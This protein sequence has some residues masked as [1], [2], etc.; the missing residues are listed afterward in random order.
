MLDHA[1]S[2]KGAH[3]LCKTVCTGLGWESA[4][5]RLPGAPYTVFQLLNHMIYWQDWVLTWLAGGKPAVPR[6]AS[7]SWPGDASPKRR[8][9][10][11]RTV[12]RFLAGLARL[13]R[14][15]RQI[16]LQSARAGKS[17]EM[18]QAIAAHN[19]YHLGQVVLLRRLLGSWPPP[20]GGLTW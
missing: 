1:L 8:R 15:S 3:V 9:E 4:G 17:L 16:D 6:H 14:C 18:L 11:E 2:G 7:G 19:S 13:S 5:R 20:S 10:W 12:S